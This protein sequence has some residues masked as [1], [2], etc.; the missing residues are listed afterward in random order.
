MD[1]INVLFQIKMLEKSI[2]RYMLKDMNQECLAKEGLQITPTQMQIID[3][4]IHSKNQTIEQSALEEI[5][6]LR[7]ATVSGV[8]Q[9]MEKNNL[10]QRIQNKEDARAKKIV[11][12]EKTKTLFLES[13][14]RLQEIEKI[15]TKN[16]EEEELQV[17]LNVISKMKMNLHNKNN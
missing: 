13:E 4:I 5:L 9:T 2:A 14:K 15:I 1:K 6:N 17:F 8:L 16:I 10:L 12:T 3:S 7:R 11:L